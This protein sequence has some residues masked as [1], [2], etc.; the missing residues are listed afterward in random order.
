MGD[1]PK[2]IIL[3]SL[4]AAIIM[5]IHYLG[6]MSDNKEKYT[7]PRVQAGGHWKAGPK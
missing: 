2:L 7:H 1:I 4:L 6:K 3:I 5:G